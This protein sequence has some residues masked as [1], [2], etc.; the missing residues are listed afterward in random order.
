MKA[1][2]E[3]ELDNFPE[4]ARLWV[5]VDKNDPDTY[6]LFPGT[7]DEVKGLFAFIEQKDAE[8]WV[9][10]LRGSAKYK[11]I[12]LG[13]RYDLLKDLRDGAREYNYP[14]WALDEK[15]AM[16]FFTRYPDSLDGYYGY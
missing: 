6:L 1:Q 3:T 13:I 2:T 8:H 16:N 10:L 5:V 14:F 11:D 12:D 4:D 7:I 9:R 15:A